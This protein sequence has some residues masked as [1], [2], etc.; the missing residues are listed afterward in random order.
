MALT[1]KK[2]VKRAIKARFALDGP[3]GAGKTMSALKIAT[4]LVPGGRVAV[5][6]TERQSAS[7][8]ANLFNFDV[9]ELETFDPRLYIEAINAAAREK[10]DVIIV[11]SLSHAWSGKDGMLDK[12]GGK[13]SS[14]RDITPMHNA[15]VDSLLTVPAHVFVTMRTHTE[16]LVTEEV[17]ERGRKKQKVERVGLKP[18][19][20]AGS[21]YEFTVV[22]DMSLDNT[23]TISK[24]RCP[25]LQGRSFVRPGE[26]VAAILR[27]WLEDGEAPAPPVDFIAIGVELEQKLQSVESPSEVAALR[28]EYRPKFKG[29]PRELTAKVAVLL[30]ATTERLTQAAQ[31]AAPAAE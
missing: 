12:A 13:F 29:A 22:G 30:D 28:T 14:W 1:F 23:M 20:K 6:D 31:A 24:S 3:A 25:A 21:E 16:Y 10:Y 4:A 17:D 7:L 19:Q 27:T 15:L 11:D 9:L 8:Y 2:A 5:I 26:D 18:L